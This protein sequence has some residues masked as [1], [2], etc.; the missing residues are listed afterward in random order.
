MHNKTPKI[1]IIIDIIEYI[2]SAF[3]IL[4]ILSV[5]FCNGQADR[6]IFGEG[7]FET[8]KFGALDGIFMVTFGGG[9]SRG[10]NSQNRGVS[11]VTFGVT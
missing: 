7:H 3:F 4:G 10:G 8:V 9:S 1:D 11:I 5:M 2:F 6:V